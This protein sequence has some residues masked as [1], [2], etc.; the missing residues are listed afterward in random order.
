MFDYFVL[1]AFLTVL[2]FMSI[3]YLFTRFKVIH[4]QRAAVVERLGVPRPTALRPGLHF[5]TPFSNI[6]MLLNLEQF[7]TGKAEFGQDK[8]RRVH[9]HQVGGQI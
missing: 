1:P 8:R 9:Q 6:R 3:I 4:G 2:F 5:I 7:Q